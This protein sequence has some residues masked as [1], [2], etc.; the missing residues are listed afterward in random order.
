MHFLFPELNNSLGISFLAASSKGKRRFPNARKLPV[1]S[2]DHRLWEEIS[3]EGKTKRH[4]QE[5][6]MLFITR[7]PSL[8]NKLDSIGNTR[9]SFFDSFFEAAKSAH[10]FESV[11]QA[12]YSIV[13]QY[14]DKRCY[15]K[16]T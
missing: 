9:D 1:P 4:V 5:V 11:E 8:T 7:V 12:R 13:M 6:A 16:L 14:L 15:G 2:I 10:G 3:I